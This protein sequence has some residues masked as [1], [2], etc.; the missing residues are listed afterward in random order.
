MDHIGCL[1]VVFQSITSRIFQIEADR[2]AVN[3]RSD[4]VGCRSDFRAGYLDAA[5][6]DSDID[7]AFEVK[8]DNGYFFDILLTESEDPS[9][10]DVCFVDKEFGIVDP[11]F[12]KTGGFQNARSLVR[13][14]LGRI[15]R[16][17]GL[18]NRGHQGIFADRPGFVFALEKRKKQHNRHKQEKC[19][20]HKSPF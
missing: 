5:K 13:Y 14:D 6:L 16:L 11:D 1:V 12:R 7:F 19:F 15:N 4:V 9:V 10:V 17:F 8:D 20:S 18:N 2:I 3:R